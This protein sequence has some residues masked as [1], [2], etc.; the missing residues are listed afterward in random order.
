VPQ[1]GIRS[2]FGCKS[3]RRTFG[4]A[5]SYLDEKVE[6]RID[7]EKARA[8]YSDLVGATG[9][10]KHYVSR[11][12]RPALEIG[13]VDNENAGE[14]GRA[15]ALKMGKFSVEGGGDV[16]PAVE[17]LAREL[18]ADVRWVSPTTGRETV[19]QCCKADCNGMVFTQGVEGESV[20]ATDPPSVAALQGEGGDKHS[21][22]PPESVGSRAEDAPA[23]PSF[24]CDAATLCRPESASHFLNEPSV[25]NIPLQ[26]ELQRCATPPGGLPGGEGDGREV[27]DL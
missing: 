17:K 27:F 10:P 9:K 19:L 12:L 22:T 4:I 3:F 23:P 16:L 1:A 5:W 2:D 20:A 6:H 14:K 21:P 11:W 25:D 7:R 18:N 26:S 13:L 8:S 15:A 24:P